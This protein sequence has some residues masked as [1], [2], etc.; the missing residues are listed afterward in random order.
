MNTF[1]PTPW[2]EDPTPRHVENCKECGLFEHGSRMIWGEGNPDA[3][4]F[5]V[6]DNP[7][8]RENK[9]S[10]PYVCGTRQTV[11][12]AAHDVG[13]NENNLYVTYIL[14]RRPKRKYE[15]DETRQICRRHL[16]EQL[17]AK[18][19]SIVF[20]LGNIAVQSFFNNHELDVKSLRGK[21]HEV[22]KFPTFVAYHPL[23]IRRRPNL[24]SLFLED[25]QQ[26]SNYYNEMHK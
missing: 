5:I 12:Q 16:K 22:G 19:P 6:L 15:K 17:E 4:I 8:E 9:A 10:E 3:S 20:C 13:L 23:A 21:M 7:G 11:Q 1:C 25:W 26:M 14:K 24:K 18:R 2:Q